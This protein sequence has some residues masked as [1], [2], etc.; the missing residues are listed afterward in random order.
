MRESYWTDPLTLAAKRVVD[1]GIV[2]VTA[3]GN[4]GR[5]ADGETALR[6][7]HRAGQRAVGAD[8]RRVQ[9]ERPMTA[10][11]RHDGGLQLA[12]ADVPRLS[13]EARPGCAR[14]RHCLAG[15]SEQHLLHHQGAELLGGTCV[16]AFKP[17]LTLS[18]TSM[19]APVVA[20]TVALML[21][22]NPALTPNAV[23]AILQ[24][25]AQQYPGYDALTQG[26][27]FLN[28]LGAVRLARLLR[29]GAAG[30]RD[31]AA[32]DLEQADHLGQPPVVWRLLN[33]YAKRL[34]RGP[35]GAPRDT[36]A[37]RTS[38][39]ARL[40]L[41]GATT[42]SGAR[43]DRDNIIWGT[44]DG[45]DNIVWGTDGEGDNI[46]WGTEVDGDNIV[47]GTD[48]GGADCDNIIWGTD[49]DGDNIIWG[50]A[51]DDDNI[52]WG[53]TATTTSSGA[54]PATGQHHLGHRRDDN[55]V[56]GTRTQVALPPSA[57][58]IPRASLG[59][60]HAI[61]SQFL[62]RLTDEQFF[63]LID[64]LSSVP[65]PWMPGPPGMPDLGLPPPPSGEVSSHGKDALF[66]ERAEDT[67][68]AQQRRAGVH[69][70]TLSAAAGATS[71]PVLS[72][73][74]GRAAR[75]AP[76]DAA[77]LFAML[78]S[79]G[80]LAVHLAAADDGRR[81]RAFHRVDASAARSRRVCL[82]RGHPQG[83]DTA[84]GLFQVRKLEPGFAARRSGALRSGRRSG[85]PAC[86]KSAELVLDFAF[87]TLGVHRL[88]ARAA[89]RNGRGNGALRRSAPCRKACCG[90]R[91]CGT[92][93][94]SIRRST[95][96][97]KTTGATSETTSI[98]SG[99][100]ERSLIQRSRPSSDCRAGLTRRPFYFS[101][102]SIG[103]SDRSTTRSTIPVQP[104]AGQTGVL[105]RQQI[106]RRRSRPTA[107]NDRARRG[108]TSVQVFRT[109]CARSSPRG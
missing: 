72:R 106:V 104:R 94:S 28:A 25:T 68:A 37:A 4:F 10:R 101:G 1:A 100:R 66:A 14:L 107:V 47:W 62:A 12:R 15:R 90:S 30:Q 46:V 7:H 52:I 31:S 11:R 92:G 17:Y 20:G 3:A 81:L 23:K 84:I 102:G 71:L 24:Y 86:S 2:V 38:S 93:S 41:T 75:A 27:G 58:S 59:R 89:V 50:T 98:G 13:G 18:G 49:G 73:R 6:R 48:C 22:A 74:A 43:P 108:S 21:Q 56:W 57:T 96:L 45:D 5:N 76:S 39:G 36:T 85:V 65:N 78:T 40:A 19:A 8:G 79:D 83:Y 99:V 32:G 69:P 54:P 77:S 60:G 91:S 95:P 88:E 16:T 63:H 51:G 55:I 80:S 9:H 53:T 42:S 97:S 70:A 44:A 61:D 64:G 33:P 26:A 35:P 82:L 67:P 87:E 109:I 29:D 34:S 105:H 103:F